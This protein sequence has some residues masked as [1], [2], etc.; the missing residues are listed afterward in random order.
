MK[1]EED[2]YKED[3]TIIDNEFIEPFVTEK[4]YKSKPK[5]ISFISEFMSLSLNDKKARYLINNK[6]RQIKNPIT[7]D[8]LIHYLCINDENY[9]LIELMKPNS[10]EMEEKNKLGQ[11][12]L[13]IAVQNKCFK[14]TKYL[15]ENGAD[16][17]SKDKKNNTP[18][19]IAAK[20]EDYNIIELLN[21]IIKNCH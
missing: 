1:K 6:I 4:D 14:I 2:E 21:I 20:N 16:V 8:T 19:N 13:H 3:D 10:I 7:L 15:I 5:I 18:L 11:T 17:H 9:P 12:L